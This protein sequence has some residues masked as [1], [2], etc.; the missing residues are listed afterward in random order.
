M[1]SIIATEECE[2]S[3]AKIRLEGALVSDTEKSFL[4]NISQI[5]EIGPPPRLGPTLCPACA[6]TYA[7]GHACTQLP[8]G[9][10]L[11]APNTGPGGVPREA[12]LQPPE[13][14]SSSQ[15]EGTAASTIFTKCQCPAHLEG[16]G[17][18][19]RPKLVVWKNKGALV[20]TGAMVISR[21][22]QLSH[23]CLRSA[24]QERAQMAHDNMGSR[25]A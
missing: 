7:H 21:R 11:V 13:G 12:S 5:S 20:Q 22:S 2:S 10:C 14:S 15:R 17:Q 23:R 16:A 25:R 24:S 4:G 18:H 8:S 9:W 1:L 19:K 6:H 3:R